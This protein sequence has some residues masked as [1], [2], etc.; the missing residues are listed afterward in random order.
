MHATIVDPA[1]TSKVGGQQE[2]AGGITAE[3]RKVGELGDPGLSAQATAVEAVSTWDPN[4][5]GDRRTGTASSSSA[6]S[7]NGKPVATEAAEQ[8]VAEPVPIELVVEPARQVGFD[9][10]EVDEIVRRLQQRFIRNGKKLIVSLDQLDWSK[11]I[12]EKLHAMEKLL[13]EYP[14]WRGVVTLFLAVRDR[15]G[16]SDKNLRKIVDGLV[17]RVNGHYGKTDYTPIHYVRHNLSQ[18]EVVALYSVADVALVTSLRE[19]LS[20]I[21]LEFIA[22]Q[23]TQ[24]ELNMSDRHRNPTLA[25]GA[26]SE[27]TGGASTSGNGQDGRPAGRRGK[28]VLVCSE[29]AGY[30]HSLQGGMTINPH[31]IPKVAL[32]LNNALRSPPGMARTRFLHL[33]RHVQTSYYSADRWAT[34]IVTALKDARATSQTGHPSNSSITPLD[35]GYLRSFYERSSRRLLVLDCDGTLMDYKP[36]PQLSTPSSKG[37]FSVTRCSARAISHVT[38]C[39]ETL[40]LSGLTVRRDDRI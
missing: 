3:E 38:P 25:S 32:A 5:D 39:V 20:L 40:F 10:M 11:G 8:Q 6:E 36:L 23:A 26:R 22:A 34:R 16:P 35:V 12:P 21:P 30:A 37:S 24:A 2:A 27:A 7:E 9:S 14:N 17:G 18:D 29:F 15:D 33:L 28:G 4:S 31:D 13:E 1:G 19:G